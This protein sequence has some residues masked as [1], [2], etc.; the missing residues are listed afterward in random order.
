MTG[1]GSNHEA[2][3]LPR[4]VAEE[5]LASEP[6]HSFPN[7]VEK[8]PA[9]AYS[10]IGRPPFDTRVKSAACGPE[11]AAH[12][13]GV[14]C[15]PRRFWNLGSEHCGISNILTRSRAYVASSYKPRPEFINNFY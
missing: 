6:E 15:L 13:C 4:K 2:T 14:V 7:A 10:E 12:V 8:W 11:V 9:Y 3:C 1:T 5:V